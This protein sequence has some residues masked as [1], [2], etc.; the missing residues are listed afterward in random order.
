[1]NEYIYDAV[2]RYTNKGILVDTNILLLLF[3]GTTNRAR[4]ER[5]KPT[6]QFTEEDY[7]LLVQFLN[8]FSKVVTTP[9]ILTEVNS[10]IN[11]LGEPEK[12]SCLSV[13]SQGISQSLS[14]V[15]KESQIICQAAEF[16]RFGLTDCG[17]REVARED[18]LVLSDDL[19]LVNSLH[20][21]GI[22]AINF[23]HL[24]Q[25]YI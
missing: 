19:Q 10:F 15:Y 7:N 2:N 1:M 25:F 24:R 17:I 23:N 6:R 22:D 3:V 14:E 9:N 21:D 20:A 8:E 16:I 4:I 13:F 12:Q 5:F 11:K 18:Y